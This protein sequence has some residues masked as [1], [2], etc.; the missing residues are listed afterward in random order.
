[1]EKI[2]FLE[3]RIN[4]LESKL[5]RL[6]GEFSKAL[7]YSKSDPQASL[8]KVRSLLEK[9]I[10]EIY[11]KEMKVEP[12]NKSLGSILM[13]ENFKK[14]I[15][16]NILSRIHSIRHMAN[17]G[18]H[19]GDV[20]IADAIDTV[21]DLCVVFEWYLKK[22]K[23][24]IIGPKNIYYHT[25][26][27]F[28]FGMKAFGAT[29]LV[30]LALI[31]IFFVFILYDNNNMDLPSSSTPQITSNDAEIRESIIKFV[32]AYQESYKVN[33]IEIFSSYY[34]NSFTYLGH[35]NFTKDS[36]MIDKAN[37]FARWP[38]R[39]SFITSEID[40]NKLNDTIYNIIYNYHFKVK[41]A[42][43]PKL[44]PKKGEI[45]TKLKIWLKDQKPLIIEVNE[46]RIK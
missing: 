4:I 7:D 35:K 5:D 3:D 18:V 25:V 21:E 9:L 38:E 11:S 42:F 26:K 32:K 16:P 15:S 39:E 29:L 46:E 19:G 1:M 12:Q 17:L 31:G 41:D 36:L 20:S 43:N 22:Y 45:R 23:S 13:E 6:S 27:A 44:D 10:L 33:D 34:N 30:I 24:G 28:S 40:I 14:K 8:T 37:Y 2:D